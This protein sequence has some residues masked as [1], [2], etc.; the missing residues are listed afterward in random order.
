[1]DETPSS[2]TRRHAHSVRLQTQRTSKDSLASTRTGVNFA[3]PRL[4]SIRS[5]IGSTNLEF[6]HCEPFVQH[7]SIFSVLRLHAIPSNRPRLRLVHVLVPSPIE[8]RPMRAIVVPSHVRPRLHNCVFL[9]IRLRF[10]TR[11][12]PTPRRFLRFTTVFFLMIFDISQLCSCWACSKVSMVRPWPSPFRVHLRRARARFA[13][14]RRLFGAFGSFGSDVGM[15]MEAT[16]S[17]LDVVERRMLEQS[18]AW[19]KADVFWDEEYDVDAYIRDLKAI[20]RDAFE[21]VWNGQG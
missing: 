8:P 1:M 4:W 17:S 7:N 13:P 3:C 10:P 9:S 15:A 2:T 18:P 20:V 6:V 5:S 11:V 21:R 19:L 12:D 14:F 16:S